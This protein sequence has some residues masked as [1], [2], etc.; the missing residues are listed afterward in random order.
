M[1]GAGSATVA[2][3]EEPSFLTAP[4]DPTYV[5]PGRNPQ[6]GEANLQRQLQRMRVE[7]EPEAVDSLAGNL[8]GAFSITYSMSADTHGSIRDLVFNDGG[9]G[10]VH[11]HAN[12]SRWYLGVEYLDSPTTTATAE[13]V[14][15]GCIP[16]NYDISFNQG[17]NTIRESLSMGYAD[18]ERNTSITPGSITGP[19][20]DS[21]VAFHGLDL[22]IDGVSVQKLQQATL[23]FSGP[24][25]RFQ[26]GTDPR[27]LDAILAAPSKSLQTTATFG[28]QGTDHLELAYGSSSGASSTQDRLDNV[29]ATATFDVE[30][31][32]VASYSLP[33][34]KPTQYGWSDLVNPD[35]DLTEPVQWHVNGQI[36][37]S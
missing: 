32:T 14:L 1:T 33:K 34:V 18:E 31:T 22:Q 24:L 12:S 21:D 9:A 19:T 10:F 29:A 20:D 15:Q 5:R 3:A 23:S 28:D 25:Y 8:E 37:V 17:T 2:F 35:T 27:P 13:R 4:S 30:G 16:L 26:R 6:V 36:Q 11:G 7:D